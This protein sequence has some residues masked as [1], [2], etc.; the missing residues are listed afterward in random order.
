MVFPIGT[1][2]A[3]ISA[4]VSV[5]YI[6][7]NLFQ[8]YKDKITNS[9]SPSQS[10]QPFQLNNTSHNPAV[11]S[12]KALI[13]IL[14]IFLFSVWPLIV[15]LQYNRLAQTLIRVRIHQFL[16]SLVVPSYFYLTNNSLRQFVRDEF[17]PWL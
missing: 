7:R 11:I 13:F 6:S 1:Y 12:R 9:I 8:W 15:M 17:V 3:I 14:V 4:I 2:L 16:L 10:P 5:I